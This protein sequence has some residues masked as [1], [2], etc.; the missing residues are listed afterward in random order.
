M[1]KQFEIY[2]V[3]HGQ[4][5]ANETNTI[6]G[7]TST[8][9]SDFGRKQAATLTERLAGLDFSAIYSSDLDRAMDTARIAVPSM[10]PIPTLELRE[11][12]LGIFQGLTRSEVEKR[13]PE[14]WQ[15]FL[16]AKP[17][18]RIPGGESTADVEARMD[19]FMNMIVQR[20]DDGRILVVSHCGALRAMLKRVLGVTTAW[21]MQPQVANASVSRFVCKDG[22]WQLACWNDTAHLKGLIATTGN[23]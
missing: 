14:A 16:D 10:A 4:S 8:P 19:S 12:N 21:P 3:R 15:A 17:G 13:Y 11:W 1:T 20:H 7:Q 9:L 22:Q 5:V 6:Q 18:Y 23:Y 2:A